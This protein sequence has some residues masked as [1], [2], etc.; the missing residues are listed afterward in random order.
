MTDG[1]ANPTGAATCGTRSRRGPGVHRAPPSFRGP[2][3]P[4]ATE[5]F[6]IA[7]GTARPP[8]V[9]AMRDQPPAVDGVVRFYDRG[10]ERDRLDSGQGALELA[11]TVAIL[12]RYL[13]RPPAVVADV[14]GGP[15]RY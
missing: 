8:N 9:S 3:V 4:G 2:H 13:P 11:R 10:L 14:G 7:R 6:R 12:E 5:R 15:G 1:S